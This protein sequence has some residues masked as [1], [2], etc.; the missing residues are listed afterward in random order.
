MKKVFCVMLIALVCTLG[1]AQDGRLV[2]N[3]PHVDTSVISIDAVMDEAAWAE[4][5]EANLVTATSYAMY[6]LY[7]GR[8]SLTEPDFDE[9][10]ARLLWTPETLYVFIHIDEIV[11]DTTDLHWDGKWLGD[12]LFVSLSARLGEE[13]YGWYDGNSARYPEGPYH[14]WILGDQVTLNGG[15][16]VW[17]PDQYQINESDYFRLPDPA[18]HVRWATNIDKENGVWDLELAIYNPHVAAQS[19]LGFNLG[20][21]VGSTHSDTTDGDAY[22]YYTWQPNVPDDPFGVPENAGSPGDPGWENLRS[23]AN[24]AVLNFLPPVSQVT[25]RKEVT[26]PQ[27]NPLHMTIDAKMDEANWAGAGEANLVTATSYEMYALY[28]G[29]ESLTEPDFDEYYARL[30]W[31]PETLYVFIHMDEIVNDTTDLHWDGKWLGDQLFVSLSARLGEELY[32]WYDGNSA[33]YPEGPYHLWILGDQVTLNGGDTVWVPDKYIINEEDYFRLPDPADH[34]RWA[35]NIDKENGI[36]DLELAIYNPNVTSQAVLGFNLGGSVGST[37]SDTTDGDAYAYYTWQPNVPDDPFGVPENA[38]SPGDPGWEN[39]RS[40]ANWAVLMF[41]AD[42]ATAIGDNNSGVSTPISFG[43]DQNYPNP[44]NPS[45]S[46]RFNLRDRSAV[47]LKVYN[48]AGQLVTT[49]IDG[50]V[51]AGGT[52]V[53]TW[54]AGHLASGVYFYELSAQGNTQTKKM[55]LMK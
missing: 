41:D 29:R 50:Q 46:I 5:G 24:W 53:V 8:E 30:L 51:Y 12:Q 47:T 42:M 40:S 9:Y 35:T 4:A 6:A 3:V 25:V 18:D 21:S 27:T 7:Y 16:T 31:S 19:E 20:G 52:Y 55:V 49:L 28:Y 13:L 38:G 33:R 39:L 1:F 14:L 36:W 32:G 11:N 37:H 44:F 26:V 34:V 15:D 23:S 45:T 10:Y 2:V 48:T 43:L 54:D 17:V 22:A